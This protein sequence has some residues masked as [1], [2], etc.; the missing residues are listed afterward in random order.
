MNKPKK[1]VRSSGAPRSANRA[2]PT[3]CAQPVNISTT[4]RYTPS[5]PV[6][7]GGIDP[8]VHQVVHRILSSPSDSDRILLDAWEKIG[9]RDLRAHRKPYVSDTLARTMSPLGIACIVRYAQGFED[10]AQALAAELPA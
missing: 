7:L 4:L 10:E 8:V 6:L 9:R 1:S 5:V 3:T 2:R